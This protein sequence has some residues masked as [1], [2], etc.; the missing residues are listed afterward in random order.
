MRGRL[1]ELACDIKQKLEQHDL[2]KLLTTINGVDAQ[3]AAYLIAKLGDPARFHGAAALAS[4]VGIAP[5]L[6]QSGKRRFS[7][8]AGAPSAQD[9]IMVKASQ[10]D[11]RT[12][13]RLL[14]PRGPAKC[15]GP[16]SGA[17]SLR[18]TKLSQKGLPFV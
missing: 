14:I 4:Y 13:Q 18:P 6:R 2:G 16:L 7:G 10:T 17:A 8:T 3:T 15:G 12:H 1:R 5:R 11:S 9:V